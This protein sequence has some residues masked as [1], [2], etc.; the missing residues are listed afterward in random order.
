VR[1]WVAFWDTR[2]SIYVNARHHQAHC[3]RIADDLRRYLPKGGAVL[4]YGCGE[5]LAADQ[6]ARPAD[7]L[8]LCEAAPAVRATLTRRFAGNG[9]IVVAAPDEVAAMAPQSLD[10][11][12][13][14]SVAQYLTPEELDAQLAVFRRL[15]KPAGMLLL[16][17][18]IPTEVSAATDALALLRFGRNEGFFFAALFG[19]AR[20]A[21]S[22]YWALR[23]KLGL[24]RY[25]ER[26]II[27]KLQS[28]GF[29]AVR[30]ADN[31]GH[32]PAR[33]TFLARP[34]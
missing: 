16:G 11:I 15:L 1:D 23:S 29:A 21:F 32:N 25:G 31:I 12:V 28:A 18:V 33:M 22:N 10:L 5:A 8:I 17:D 6:I 34:H 7:R 14:H 3:R 27:D 9:K 19:L 2:H 30:S 24:T 26:A 4:D 20:T 13:M